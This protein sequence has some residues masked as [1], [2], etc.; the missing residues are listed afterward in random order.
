MIKR[1]P[2]KKYFATYIK[3]AN[4]IKLLYA[5]YKIQWKMERHYNTHKWFPLTGIFLVLLSIYKS[6]N[7]VSFC[8]IEKPQ[9]HYL[10]FFRPLLSFHIEA[11]YLWCIF[12]FTEAVSYNHIAVTSKNLINFSDD[13]VECDYSEGKGTIKEVCYLPV[14]SSPWKR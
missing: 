3:I 8:M 10:I 13:Y 4:S 12:S 7:A 11:D 6:E 2:H 9:C 14:T 5:E 1:Y